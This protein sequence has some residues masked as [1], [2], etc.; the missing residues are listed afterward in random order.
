MPEFTEEQ[1]RKI[2]REEVLKRERE[3]AGYIA[4]VHTL[5]KEKITALKRP[6]NQ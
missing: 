6:K 4:Q 5:A 2:A 3:R 1:I